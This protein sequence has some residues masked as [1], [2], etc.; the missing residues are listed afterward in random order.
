MAIKKQA[1]QKRKMDTD[2]P[3]MPTLDVPQSS[4]A[5][6][7]ASEFNR[8]IQ[9]WHRDSMDLWNRRIAALEKRIDDLET[10]A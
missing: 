2:W 10:T 3:I 1:Q 4:K 7:A 8:K 9:E 6:L 5:S